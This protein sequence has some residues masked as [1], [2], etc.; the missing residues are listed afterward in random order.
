MTIRQWHR[1]IGAAITPTMTLSEQLEAAGLNWTVERSPYRYGESFQHQDDTFEIAYRSDTAM[2]LDRHGPRRNVFQNRQIVEAFHDFCASSGDGLT[3]E[4]LGCLA[5]GKS[6]FATAKLD[7]EIDVAKVGDRVE[8]RI[9][10]KESHISGVALQVRVY[11]NR[12]VCT[13][14]MTRLVKLGGRTLN[15]MKEFD[16][17]TVREYLEAAYSQTEKYEQ[18]LNQLAGITISRPEAKM[19]LVKAFGDETLSWEEQ[20][21]AVRVCFELFG[22]R[23]AGSEMLSAYDTLFGLTEAVKEYHNWSMKGS[24]SERAFGSLCFGARGRAQDQFLKQAV[25]LCGV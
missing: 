16:A 10:L 14:G 17:R 9:L 20:P 7:H 25:S 22:G 12:L 21:R 8:T 2:V 15:H 13:N 5:G 4:R 24:V 23:G 11:F 1:N 18:T 6:L 3:I 19:Q